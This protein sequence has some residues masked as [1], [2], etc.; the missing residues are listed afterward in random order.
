MADNRM[1][2]QTMRQVLERAVVAVCC[3]AWLAGPL[4]GQQKTAPASSNEAA[5][6]FREAANFQ[7]NGAFEIAAE[8]WQKFL[9]DYPK[10]AYATKAR[11]YLGVCQLQMKQ[12]A[13][14]AASFEAVIAADAKF[15]LLDDAYFDLATCQYALAAGGRLEM[16]PKAAA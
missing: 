3:C 16:Y 9:K 12:Y 1:T 8:E 6:A 15:E 5:L 14:A 13:A 7:N 4:S 2:M 11:H 10:D